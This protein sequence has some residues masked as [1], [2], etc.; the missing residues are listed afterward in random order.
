M[1]TKI[2]VQLLA[3]LAQETR[4]TLFKRLVEAGPTGLAA[5]EI[6]AALGLPPATLS[7]HLKEM[8]RADLI[9]ARQQGRFIFYSADFA[10]MN[11]LLGFLTENCCARDGIACAPASACCPPA[12]PGAK[13][14]RKGVTS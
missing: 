12:T 6:A 4:L 14:A 7:F 1:E 11:D 3:A 2:A 9:V 8:S 5:G 10:R 13:P